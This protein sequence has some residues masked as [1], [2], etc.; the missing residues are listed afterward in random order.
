MC[1][2][3]CIFVRKFQLRV[4]MQRIFLVVILAVMLAACRHEQCLEQRAAN[5]CK[6]IPDCGSLEKSRDYLTPDFYA[7]LDTMCHQLPEHEVMD[8]QYNHW[9]V[10]DDDSPLADSPCDVLSVTQQD[11]T[12]AEAALNE[13]HLMALER[14]DGQWLMADFDG[15]KADAVRYIANTRKEQ[16]LR[17]A[18]SD[19]LIRKIAPAYPQGELC[20]PC[21]MMTEETDT[22]VWGDFWVYWYE[23]AGDTLRIVSGGCHPGKMSLR[24]EDGKPHVVRFEPAKDGTRFMDVREDV[25]EA[26]RR[27][28]LQEFFRK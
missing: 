14:V 17:A 18:I 13:N 27:E 19:Y 8:H 7:I 9:F 24:Y 22:C 10:T 5:L 6:Y 25:R 16:A 15:H 11:A 1:K 4:I 21:L 12:H 2:F 23:T 26:V 3:L 28:Q 20:V